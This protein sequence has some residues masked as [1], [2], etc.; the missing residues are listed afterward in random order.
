MCKNYDALML[1]VGWHAN[2][3]RLAQQIPKVCTSVR[4]VTWIDSR[5]LVIFN[6]ISRLFVHI[7]FLGNV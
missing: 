1:L 5:K 3:N 7:L 6:E 2:K 4:N